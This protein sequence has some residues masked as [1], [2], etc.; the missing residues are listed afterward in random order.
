VS[1]L[2]VCGQSRSLVSVV[3]D[4][5][6]F[7]ARWGTVHIRCLRTGCILTISSGRS[8]VTVKKNFRPVIARFSEMGEV[9]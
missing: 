5:C 1:I 9:P 7:Y 2:A 8:S 6:I 3:A 4:D